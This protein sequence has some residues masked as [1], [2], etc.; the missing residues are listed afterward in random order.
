[1][2]IF[3]PR[4]QVLL[5]NVESV[6]PFGGTPRNP[7]ATC[8]TTFN[9]AFQAPRSHH[10]GFGLLGRLVVGGRGTFDQSTDASDELQ[11]LEC[12]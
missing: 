6:P 10:A 3:E 12:E 1:M 9:S 8:F 5:P 2:R 7:S 11:R 4:S